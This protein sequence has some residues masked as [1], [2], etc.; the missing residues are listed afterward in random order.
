MITTAPPPLAPGSRSNAPTRLARRGLGALD[1]QGRHRILVGPGRVRRHRHIAGLRPGGQLTYVMT[2]TEPEQVR[3]H[4]QRRHAAL[5]RLHRH[6]YRSLAAPSDWSLRCPCPTSCREV[7]P[8]EV[9]TVVEL[10]GTTGGVKMTITFDAM[11]DDVWT[12]R[13]RAGHQSQMRKLDAL[14]RRKG[15]RTAVNGSSR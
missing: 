3:V 11:H 5:H 14:R 6:L 2:A 12:E 9:A 13:A 1:H 15:Q 7:T 8:Y 4:D 10:Q